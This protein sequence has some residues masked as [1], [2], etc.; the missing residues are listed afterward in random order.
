MIDLAL[1]L[2]RRCPLWVISG[3]FLMSA[4]SLNDVCPPIDGELSLIYI[5]TAS[6]PDAP[7]SQKW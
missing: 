2:T 4:F 5:L 7:D 3:H 1:A 6:D